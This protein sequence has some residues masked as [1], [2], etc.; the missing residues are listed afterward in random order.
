[1]NRIGKLKEMRRAS[2][3]KYHDNFNRYTPLEINVKGILGRELLLPLLPFR[4][5]AEKMVSY[6]DYF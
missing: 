6:Y 5:L 4:Q 3:N 2:V 1:M